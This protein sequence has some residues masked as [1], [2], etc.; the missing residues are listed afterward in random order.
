MNADLSFLKSQ[1]ELGK[2]LLRLNPIGTE[3]IAE[4]LTL[5]LLIIVHTFWNEMQMYK[6]IEE[7]YQLLV[8]NT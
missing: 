1:G 5:V 8:V 3:L 2:K 4:F 6:V 7:L